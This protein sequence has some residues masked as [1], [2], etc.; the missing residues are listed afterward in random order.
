MDRH[1][2]LHRRDRLGELV[3]E[4]FPRQRGRDDDDDDEDDNNDDDR[5]TPTRT[6]KQSGQAKWPE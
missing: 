6:G 5:E 4:L 1:H 3:E 2:I